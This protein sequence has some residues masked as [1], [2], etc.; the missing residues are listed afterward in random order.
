MGRGSGAEG[1]I[2][3]LQSETRAGVAAETRPWLGSSW[4]SASGTR[5]DSRQQKTTIPATPGCGHGG[6]CLAPCRSS[7]AAGRCPKN[8]QLQANLSSRARWQNNTTW[9]SPD[10]DTARTGGAPRRIRS[11][12]PPAPGSKQHLG[13]RR[14]TPAQEVEYQPQ[15]PSAGWAGDRGHRPDPAWGGGWWRMWLARQA[16]IGQ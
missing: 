16:P 9:T 14:D 2:P 5:V 13:A 11:T 15:P 10:L 3:A 7:G 8:K 6:D 1:G 4:C 12:A